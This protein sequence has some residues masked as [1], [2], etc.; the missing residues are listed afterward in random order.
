MLCNQESHDGSHGGIPEACRWLGQKYISL[1]YLFFESA[2]FFARAS[3]ME[4]IMKKIILGLMWA[5]AAALVC[6]CAGFQNN[7]LGTL[8]LKLSLET[9]AAQAKDALG[10]PMAGGS[11]SITPSEPWHPSRYVISGTGPGGAEFSIESAETSTETKLV[12]GEWSITVHAFS[13]AGKEVASGTSLCV[14]QPG[15][16]TAT[17]IILFPIE[18]TGDLTLTIVKNFQIPSGGRISGTL[19]YKGLPGSTAASGQAPLPIDIPAEQTSIVF[20]GIP[21]GHYTIALKLSDS[22]EIVAG[23]LVETI[24][25][26]AGFLT[27]GTC[28]IVMGSPLV[29]LSTVLFPS[30]PLPAP[31]LSANHT[32]S[33]NHAFLPLA[34]SRSEGFAG[35]EMT[36]QWFVNGEEIGPGVR[37]IGNLGIL[38]PNTMVFPP[39]SSFVSP[40]STIR[41]D[42]VEESGESF[43]TGSAG[44]LARIGKSIESGTYGWRT[45]YDYSSAA[46]PALHESAS[47]FNTGAGVSYTVKAIAGSPSGLIA[48][49]GLD[50]DGAMH[51]FAAG[52]GA[53]LD[54]LAGTGASTLSIDASWIKLWRD[55]IK[56]GGASKN[57]DR[58]AISKDG[59]FIAAASSVSTWLRVYALDIDG[60]ILS[61]FDLTSSVPN[62]GEFSNIKALCFSEDGKTLYAAANSPEAVYSFNIDRAGVSFASMI[63]L[64]R[65]TGASL[66]MQDLKV[67]ASGAIVATSRDA[68]RIYL[69][70]DSG[71]LSLEGI[72]EKATDGS[73]PNNP[74]SIAV[75]TEGDAFYVL[76]SGNRGI[77]FARDNPSSS[78]AQAA[79]F[80]LPANAE[81]SSC[82]SAGKNPGGTAEILFA[83]GGTN[84]AF[85]EMGTDR[86]PFRYDSLAPLPADETGIASA[87][88]ACFVRG[89]FILA[90]GSAGK[91]SVFGSD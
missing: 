19:N 76:C 78:Y 59:A 6:A 3:L 14:L 55:E 15:R 11:K 75:S 20:Q 17:R 86:L 33:E 28:T 41:A 91:V 62:L 77:C 53:V 2:A 87:N 79:S 89:A 39:D 52:Y 61:S 46:G 35:E 34:V 38:P 10:R 18:G 25:V 23:G 44:L 12:P 9:G 67:T 69:I 74:S 45:S 30:S 66:M 22:D 31:L 1:P 26:M 13:G 54:P 51:A 37:L 58:L 64:Q 71:S 32:V 42:Y 16:T 80:S 50:K 4:E 90:G 27:E 21:A 36:R 88:G 82:L 24:L 72:I 57:A 81:S 5:A 48:V 49:A 65:V 47:S 73:G 8:E 7:R 68:S 56:I 84:I 85:I 60:N 83:S 40:V 63:A 43:Q 29:D 70:G